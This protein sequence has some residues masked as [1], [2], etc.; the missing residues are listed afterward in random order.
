MWYWTLFSVVS[1]FLFRI[2]EASV[3]VVTSLSQLTLTGASI[4]KFSLLNRKT[5]GFSQLN[6]RPTFFTFL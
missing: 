4:L 2:I 1:V 3:I 6:R 5:L